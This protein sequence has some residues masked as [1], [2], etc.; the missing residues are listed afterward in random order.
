MLVSPTIT[1]R[2]L[3]L[4]DP[5]ANVRTRLGVTIGGLTIVLAL[6]LSFGVGETSR[7]ELERSQGVALAE[8]GFQIADRFD[9]S[10]AERSRA[11]Q[12]LA[13]LEGLRDPAAP[14]VQRRAILES[15]QRTFPEYAWIGLADPRGVVQIST[16][17]LLEGADV[18]QRPWFI[19]GQHGPYL[20]DVHEA[21]LLAQLLPQTGDEPLRFL[22]ATAPVY[23]LNGRFQGVLGAHLSWTWARDTQASLLRDVQHQADVEVIVVSHEGL[24]LLG[25]AS[26][27]DQPL[28]LAQL[29]P[30]DAAAARVA[31]WPDGQSYLT[32]VQTSQIDQAGDGLG[33]Q[34]LVRQ[35]T[36]TAFASARRLEQQVLLWGGFAGVVFGAVSWL[37]AGRIVA[38]V[39]S[40]AHV[41]ERIQR[42]ARDV[43]IPQI[44]G[45]DEI[46]MLSTTL[47]AL[48]AD[49]TTREQERIR[50]YDQAQAAI[51]KRDEFLSVAAHELKT[52]ITNLRGFVQVVSRQ[53]DR[54]GDV[55]PA[56][57]HRSL[58]M[59]E[60]QGDKLARLVGQLLDIDNGRLVLEPAPTDLAALVTTL[61]ATTAANAPLHTLRVD[62]P[63]HVVLHIDPVRIE[64]VL[65]NLLDN[66]IKY[67]PS[68]GVIEVT[69]VL[70]AADQ[71][72]ISVRDYG[73]GIAP[74][75]R[76][77]LFDRLFQAHAQRYHGG[78]GLGLYLSQQIVQGHGGR[79]D[80]EF[81]TD[82]GTRFVIRLPNR[83]VTSSVSNG[84][85]H[86]DT[87]ADPVR[88]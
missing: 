61:V 5:R 41:A 69:L 86:G 26:L 87:S 31:R 36:D 16:Q 2:L 72:V 24:V 45:R 52:P 3:L 37:L 28:P 14:P 21:V 34:V 42:G 84:V 85:D 20:G 7:R 11:V 56:R 43:S 8:L 76:Q 73:V 67:S 30:H 22:D 58:T 68:G 78:L 50:L 35:K 75:Q 74:E 39:V 1:Q 13:S 17:Q 66:A 18:S 25:P 54:T 49:L 4:I 62:T 63:P 23:D 64:Q 59:I 6:M 47:A 12:V 83:S 10:L 79:L 88:G 65:A 70:P 80:A 46:A 15:L 57:L 60:Q 71:A 82:G 53:I 77:H 19:H 55:D 33:W 40:I 51:A 27:Q 32:S 81:P 29:R 9:Q 44:N 38:P 48:V